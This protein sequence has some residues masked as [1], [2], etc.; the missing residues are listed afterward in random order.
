MIW[1]II[2]ILNSTEIF[3]QKQ[4]HTHTL[5]HITYPECLWSNVTEYLFILDTFGKRKIENSI[6]PNSEFFVHFDGD[7]C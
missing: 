4:T 2:S 1:L 6:R 3:S 7:G 5:M